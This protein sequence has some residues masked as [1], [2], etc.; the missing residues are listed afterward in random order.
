MLKLMQSGGSVSANVCR[1]K[2]SPAIAMLRTCKRYHSISMGASLVLK[3]HN[4]TK[5]YVCTLIT[6][7]KVF[8]IITLLM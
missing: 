8:N 1:V 3:Y 5:I 7:C 6:V 4:N 2:I